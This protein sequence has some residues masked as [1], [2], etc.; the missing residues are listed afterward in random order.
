M[1]FN[2]ETYNIGKAEQTTIQQTNEVEQQWQSEQQPYQ[3]QYSQQGLID[4]TKK[5]N[6]INPVDNISQNEVEYFARMAQMN[7]MQFDSKQYNNQY[8]PPINNQYIQPINNHTAPYN[9]NQYS[10]PINQ[11]MSNEKTKR[12]FKISE[13][14]IPGFIIVTILCF[15]ITILPAMLV[16]TLHNGVPEEL[17]A[18]TTPEKCAVIVVSLLLGI[19]VVALISWFDKTHDDFDIM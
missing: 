12:K 13:S 4:L 7:N 6:K 10:A 2:G 16:D 1:K 5:I 19:A 15:I 11:P 3:Q 17:A 14:P 8:M 9:Y 18:E